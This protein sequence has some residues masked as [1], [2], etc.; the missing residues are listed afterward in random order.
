M[1]LNLSDLLKDRKKLDS[2]MKSVSHEIE[3]PNG[4]SERKKLL[5]KYNGSRVLIQ[6][7]FSKMTDM[8]Y[9][10][11]ITIRYPSIKRGISYFDAVYNFGKED[12]FSVP[13]GI[14]DLRRLIVK[15]R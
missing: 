3:V 14:E 7:D 12:E 10:D 4:I 5:K 8:D 1:V 9:L 15:E 6:A 11:D 13:L 2:V